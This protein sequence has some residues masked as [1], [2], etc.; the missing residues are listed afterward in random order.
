MKV[1]P[2]NIQIP[3]L[4]QSCCVLMGKQKSHPLQFFSTCFGIPNSDLGPIYRRPLAP[5]QKIRFKF[6]E[7]FVPKGFF[8]EQKVVTPAAAQSL[9]N[10]C[11]LLAD[12][13]LEENTSPKFARSRLSGGRA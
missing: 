6:L 11:V 9:I 2:Q 8:K 1:R 10:S 4:G 3:I 7:M 12:S 13:W 5:F